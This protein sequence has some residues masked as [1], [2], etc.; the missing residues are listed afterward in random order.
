MSCLSAW[1]AVSRPSHKFTE[2]K[3]AF[4]PHESARLGVAMR[5]I[6]T[7]ELHEL[8]V[9]SLGLD[10]SSLDLTSVECIAGA[11]R[12]AAGFLCPCS[13]TRLAEEVMHPLLDLVTDARHVREVIDTTLEALIAYG[14]LLECRKS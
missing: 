5:R 3:Y 7:S 4:S 14:D 8:G 13:D 9:K 12:R 2:G 6:T 1:S 11:L 10:P